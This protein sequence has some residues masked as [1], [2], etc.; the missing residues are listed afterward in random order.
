[1]RTICGS[2]RVHIIMLLLIL[3]KKMHFRIRASL[4]GVDI[5]KMEI[6]YF[7]GAL[8]KQVIKKLCPISALDLSRTVHMYKRQQLN[9]LTLYH[10]CKLLDAKACYSFS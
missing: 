10:F 5:I 2:H 9:K 7:W 3:F 6:T 1:M 4:R 8:G